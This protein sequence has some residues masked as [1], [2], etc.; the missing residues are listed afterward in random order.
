MFYETK[1]VDFRSS[2]LHAEV[3]SEGQLKSHPL[4]WSPDLSKKVY[5]CPG[6]TNKIFRREFLLGD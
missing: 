2:A 1:S 4:K 6:L 5:L 3:I